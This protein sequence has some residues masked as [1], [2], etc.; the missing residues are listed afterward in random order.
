MYVY[1]RNCAFVLR[2][3]KFMRMQR[4]CMGPWM[5][6][7]PALARH[8]RRGRLHMARN[9]NALAHTRACL[10]VPVS[11]TLPL[12]RTLRILIHSASAYAV[13]YG[14]GGGAWRAAAGASI[15]TGAMHHRVDGDIRFRARQCRWRSKVDT[16]ATSCEVDTRASRKPVQVLCTCPTRRGW[17]VPVVAA[18]ERRISDTSREAMFKRAAFMT[19]CLIYMFM[20]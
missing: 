11:L 6:M 14:A 1:V 9:V 20:W 7:H 8:R 3:C 19:G 2:R 4:M 5:H 16:I 15:S 18:L 13:V 17:L 10:R 12:A